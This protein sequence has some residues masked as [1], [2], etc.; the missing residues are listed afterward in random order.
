MKT[1]IGNL[2]RVVRGVG[3]VALIGLAAAGTIGVWGYVGVIPLL[4]AVVGSCP[5]YTLIGVTTCPKAR[6]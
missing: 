3:G 2:D 6:T 4:T 1:N 5:L